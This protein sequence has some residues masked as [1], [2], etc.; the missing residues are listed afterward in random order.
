M[1]LSRGEWIKFVFQDDFIAP[2]CIERMLDFADSKNT[3]ICCKRH[4]RFEE[5]VNNATREWFTNQY[6]KYLTIESLF[7][8]KKE[9]S[10]EDIS[11]TAIDRLGIN[12]F[13]EPTTMLIHRS[14]LYKFGIFNPYFIQICD[15]E[16][17]LRVCIHTG[18][19]Y[20]PETLATFRVHKSSASLANRGESNYRASVLDPLLLLHEFTFNPMY[21]P[22][23]IA[24]AKRNPPIDLVNLCAYETR[25][26]RKL[27]VEEEDNSRKA[28]AK[29][30]EAW[31]H[32]TRSYPNIELLSKK[33]SIHSKILKK[34]RL[35]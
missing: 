11:H 14:N 26:V 15:L 24:C 4:I 8:G 5:G 27:I 28:Q 2:N 10:T 30:L 12:F 23:R 25:N 33:I 29:R 7:P 17:W 32:L 18:L 9:I 3:V 19:I 13:G 16:Y 1:E 34:L 35:A 6:L 20:I 22:L 21:E 31:K